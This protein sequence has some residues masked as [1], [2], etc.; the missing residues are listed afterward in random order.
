[1]PTVIED[2][3]YEITV[4]KEIKTTRKEI[5]L[6]EEEVQ[7]IL[8]EKLRELQL[9]SPD[10]VKLECWHKYTYEYD[11]FIVITYVENPKE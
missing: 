10:A 5:F 7:K 9:V 8:L 4:S 2:K 11:G 1:M 3:D 6:D